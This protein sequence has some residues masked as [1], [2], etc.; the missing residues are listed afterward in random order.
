MSLPREEARSLDDAVEFLCDLSSGK[1]KRIPSA[2]RQRARNV[3]RHFPLAAGQRWL[4]MQETERKVDNMMVITVVEDG[5]IIVV[6]KD[7]N[8][9]RVEDDIYYIPTPEGLKEVF[10]YEASEYQDQF[11]EKKNVGQK[12]G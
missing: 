3:L 1:E 8:S 4:D 12:L 2:T 9:V 11:P 5:D 6:R 10:W 7:P